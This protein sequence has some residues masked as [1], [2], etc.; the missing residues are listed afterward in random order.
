MAEVLKGR[1]AARLEPP[2][3]VFLI[4]LRVN[5]LMAVNHWLPT[6]LEMPRM[7]K[8]MSGHEGLLS[9]RTVFYWRGVEVIQYWRSFEAIEHFARDT[10]GPHW[11]AWRRFYQK[12]RDDGPV[13]LWHETY[14]IEKGGFETLYGNM[15]RFGLGAAGETVSLTGRARARRRLDGL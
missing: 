13:G 8:A 11:P 15:P 10:A 1:H 5:R 9:S 7:L 6:L 12:A 14:V 3:V 2:F 4:G